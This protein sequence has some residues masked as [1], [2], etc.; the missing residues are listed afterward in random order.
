MNVKNMRISRKGW[1]VDE[2][3]TGEKKKKDGKR[4]NE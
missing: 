4:R 1:E 2:A 3:G